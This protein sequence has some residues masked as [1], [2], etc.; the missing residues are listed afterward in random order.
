[1]DIDTIL[2]IMQL[3]TD[4]KYIPIAIIVIGWL[5]ALTSDWSRFPINVPGRFQPLVAAMLGIAYGALHQ[6]DG[7]MVW[8]K[9]IGG[10]LVVGLT[11]GGLYDVVINAVFDGNVPSWLAWLAFAKK[12]PPAMP[13]MSEHGKHADDPKTPVNPGGMRW[14][15]KLAF[16]AALTSFL[17]ACGLLTPAQ[18]A[19]GILVAKDIACVIENAYIDDALLN[20]VC[21]LRSPTQQQAGKELASLHRTGVAKR[22]AAMHVISVTDGGTTVV[23]FVHQADAG[24]AEGGSK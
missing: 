23:A 22:M 18:E 6:I 8:W 19:K 11:T 13:P 2:K 16:A 5:V 12:S 14:S 21:D 10:G 15:F 20:T 1:M 3:G 24:T 9:A 7:G 4:H 17:M